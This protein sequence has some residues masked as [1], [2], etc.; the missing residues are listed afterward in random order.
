MICTECN[1]TIIG[2]EKCPLCNAETKAAVVSRE[3]QAARRGR[4]GT[5]L[6]RLIPAWAKANKGKCS[7]KD[8]QAKMDRW[9]T[10][11]CREHYDEIVSHLM[12]QE[13]HLISPLRK[14][15]DRL[16]LMLA[17]GLVTWAINRSVED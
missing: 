7:C 11:G 15:P 4:P 3:T 16:K 2:S 17:K 6:A 9:G 5:A 14:I 13:T 12:K 8:Y 1:R 10:D